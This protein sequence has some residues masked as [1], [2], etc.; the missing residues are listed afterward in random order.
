MLAR[1][2]WT[3]IGLGALAVGAA[4]IFV[5]LLPATPFLLLAALSFARS[6][7]RLHHWLLHHPQF[8]PPIRDWQRHRAI[9]R[10][11]KLSAIALM[12]VALA[13]SAMLQAPGWLL[14]VQVAI[15]AGV[16]GFLLSRPNPPA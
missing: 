12:G 10:R 16:A 14:I 2:L 13:A 11:A 4:G 6:S 1:Y 7:P 9:G 5:P 15:L 8:G 3:G